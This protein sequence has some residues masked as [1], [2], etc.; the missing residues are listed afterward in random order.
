MVEF[1]TYKHNILDKKLSG[2]AFSA[3]VSALHYA[4][5]LEIVCKQVKSFELEGVKVTHM[6][7]PGSMVVL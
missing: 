5:I 7:L 3:H 6:M 2:D 4:Y 1:A